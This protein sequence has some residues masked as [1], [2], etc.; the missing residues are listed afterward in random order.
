MFFHIFLWNFSIIQIK[1]L[2]ALTDVHLC[3]LEQLEGKGSK[4]KRLGE[5]LSHVSPG[6]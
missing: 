4:Q 3:I 1:P 2:F 5:I 6:N